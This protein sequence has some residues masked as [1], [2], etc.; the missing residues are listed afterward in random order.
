[1][2]KKEIKHIHV[3]ARSTDPDTSQEAAQE[4]EQ[5]Q[6]KAA[7]S[8]LSVVELLENEGPLTDFQIIAKWPGYWEGPFSYSL[9]PKA[10][11]WAREQGF[12]KKVGYGQ[13]NGR[14]VIKWG[15]GVDV[16]TQPVCCPTCERNTRN[17]EVITKIYKNSGMNLELF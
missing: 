13:H 3:N 14:R 2:A 15:I 11:L 17:E 12:V 4:F 5:D 1:M 6:T 10:R 16:I 9:P 7:K 8:V